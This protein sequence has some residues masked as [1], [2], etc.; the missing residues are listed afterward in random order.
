MQRG[1]GTKNATGID[2]PLRD[3]SAVIYQL[4]SA[5]IHNYAINCSRTMNFFSGESS[6][7]SHNEYF[8]LKS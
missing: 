1:S 3:S 6:N 4:F 5:R 8:I 2:R 7:E